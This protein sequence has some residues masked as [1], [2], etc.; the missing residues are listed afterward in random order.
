MKRII[1]WLVGHR[2]REWA[3]GGDSDA[4]YTCDRCNCIGLR[5]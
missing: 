5:R 4:V 3:W 2:W 1:C